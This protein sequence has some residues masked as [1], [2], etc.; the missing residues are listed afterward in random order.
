MPMEMSQGILQVLPHFKQRVA[1]VP[2]L[3]GMV[4]NHLIEIS[5]EQFAHAPDAKVVLSGG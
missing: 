3:V 1:M 4:S 2:Q 5:L